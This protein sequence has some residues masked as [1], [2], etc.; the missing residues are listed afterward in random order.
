MPGMD[1]IENA[2]RRKLGAKPEWKA[3]RFE[4]VGGDFIVTGDIPVGYYKRGASKGRPKWK[5][6]GQKT[7]A[8]AADVKAE[9]DRYVKETGNCP[10]CFG[11]K[12]QLKRWSQE[13][14]K[15]MEPCKDCAGTGKAAG[16]PVGGR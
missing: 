2:A 15:E 7:I 6:P 14:G 5:L 12:E 11:T 9:M 1:H 8:T 13:H 3:F 10:E 16:A 4:A